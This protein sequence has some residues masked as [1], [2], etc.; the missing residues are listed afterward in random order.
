VGCPQQR[1]DAVEKVTG[2]AEF[3]GDLSM[4]EMVHAKVLFSRRPH[5]R[6]VR[7]DAR[8]AE[9]APGVIAVLT[10]QDVPVNEYGISE[11]D[12]PVLCAD[13]VR[14]VGERVALVVAETEEDA[15]RAR[16]LIAVEYEDLPVID[17]PEAALAPGAFILHPHRGSNVLATFRVRKGDVQA[18]F[19]RA[20]VIVEATYT[21]GAQEHAYLQPDAGL[22]WIDEN[23]CVVVKTAG[24]WAHD[25][26]RQI[27][28][29]LALPED[30]VRVIYTYVGGAFGGREDISV[31]NLL[32][33]A[34][35]RVGRPVKLV[36]TREETTIGHH[37]R[38]PMR[39]RLKWG[40]DRS[41]L[42]TAQEI[43]IL[44]D[45]GAYAST[46]EYVVASTV[47][48]GSGPYEVPNVHLDA[49]VAYTNNLPNGAFRGFGVPQAALP[50]EVHMARLADALRLDPVELR[51]RNLLREGSLTHTMAE[52]PPGLSARETL[53]AVARQAG[54]RQVGGTWHRPELQREVRP[55]V[56]R[57]LGIA[58][59]WKNVGYTLGYPETSTAT[60]ELHGGA[61][62]ERAVVRLAAAEVGQGIHTTIVQM[63]AEALGLPPER[64]QP[65]FSDTA[66][67]PS[68]GSVSASRMAFMAGNA[69]LGAAERAYATWHNEERP[70]VASYTYEAPSTRMLDA[71]TGHGRGAFAFAYSAAAVEIEVDTETGQ[72]QAARIIAVHDVGR[73]INP[74]VVRGQIEGGAIQALGW[75]MLENFITRAGQV[76]TPNLSTYLIPTVMDVPACFE[77]VVLE[78][79]QPLGPWGA[80]GMGEMPFLGIA[81][82]V[83][84]ALHDA[85]GVWLDGIPLTPERVLAGLP[86]S[87]R[88]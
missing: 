35:F 76:L 70:A 46:S 34:A 44:A 61:E 68:A 47:L 33:L 59:F 9:S 71:D 54:W 53:E 49:T 26:R 21:M 15:C 85:T 19:A 43:E 11:Y 13:V 7:I 69:L 36:W 73:A 4:P 60:V 67:A 88:T 23:G 30:R 6:I 42:L 1:V 57:G 39:V 2:K 74:Q 64:I 77:P 78:Q 55:G 29:S 31:H 72:I 80:T 66:E 38:H 45:G 32:A 20:D 48:L 5:A 17:S 58:A 86:A 27:A 62:V 56:V 24:Q 63:A 28:H 12:Q 51:M 10:A 75:A 79:A 83:L 3:P 50:V 84:D 65:I 8:R 40:A 52:V 41:G 22:A 37:K 25:D 16:D 82:A 87:Q 81:P 14:H 18:G